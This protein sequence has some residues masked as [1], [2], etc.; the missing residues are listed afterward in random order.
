MKIIKTWTVV[1]FSI[2]PFIIV[3]VDWIVGSSRVTSV[4]E[5]IFCP[6]FPGDYNST[7]YALSAVIQ[8]VA[9]ILTLVFT[10]SLISL[11]SVYKHARITRF[12]L[13]RTETKLLLFF[14]FL[15]IF[16][17]TLALS[18]IENESNLTGMFYFF[19]I[20]SVLLFICPLPL[21]IYG[22]WRFC[23]EFFNSRDLLRII[24][25]EGSQ[26]IGMLSEI[27]RK[28]QEEDNIDAIEEVLYYLEDIYEQIYPEHLDDRGSRTII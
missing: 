8:S 21:F 17:S 12:F 27:L 25:E 13:E 6:Y 14:M 2:M 19:A 7:R 11:Q 23:I 9:A 5:R 18:K 24:E 3:L 26:D 28:A 22:Y 16:F 15:L 20:Y 10:I 1:S 4:I